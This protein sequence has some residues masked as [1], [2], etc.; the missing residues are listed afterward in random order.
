M[1]DATPPTLGPCRAHVRR[2][3]EE[4]SLHTRRG[5]GVLEKE[6]GLFVRVRVRVKGGVVEG[7][8][9][10]HPGEVAVPCNG[11]AEPALVARRINGHG[12]AADLR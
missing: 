2:K 8:V 12:A 6:V 4:E 3:G 10:H 5:L 1:R 9:L 7:E 11:D